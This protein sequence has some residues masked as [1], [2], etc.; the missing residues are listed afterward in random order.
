MERRKNQNSVHLNEYLLIVWA[1]GKTVHVGY[2][3]LSFHQPKGAHA[4]IT[5]IQTKKTV[6]LR[7]GD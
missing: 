7:K 5:I 2:P 3:I 6:R 1:L 4:I